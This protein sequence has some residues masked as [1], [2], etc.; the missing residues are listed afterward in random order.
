MEDFEYV[1]KN[2]DHVKINTNIIDSFIK[3]IEK[4]TI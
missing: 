2:S 3:S 1:V 4:K